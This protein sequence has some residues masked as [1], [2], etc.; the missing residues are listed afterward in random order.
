M[1]LYLTVSN[2][3]LVNLNSYT[4]LHYFLLTFFVHDETCVDAV[5]FSWSPGVLCN[6]TA[7]TASLKLQAWRGFSHWHEKESLGPA[8]SWAPWL[9]SMAASLWHQRDKC[10]VGNIKCFLTVQASTA[11]LR[12]SCGLPC[13]HF[14]FS[15]LEIPQG[16]CR[17]K[18]SEPNVSMA[19]PD[20]TK[21]ALSKDF[22]SSCKPVFSYFVRLF[23][24]EQPGLVSSSTHLLTWLRQRLNPAHCSWQTCLPKKLSFCHLGVVMKPL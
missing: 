7:L 22:G 24:H 17:R 1:R 5:S 12:H 2:M 3:K 15:C 8:D 20:T 18:T 23:Q 10:K 21:A 4:Q 11:V 9:R 19:F 16:D 6:L 14:G 13:L